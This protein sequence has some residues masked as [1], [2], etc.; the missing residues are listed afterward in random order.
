MPFLNILDHQGWP[1]GVVQAFTWKQFCTAEDWRKKNGIKNENSESLRKIQ[2]KILI[3]Y[4]NF[5]GKNG[6]QIKH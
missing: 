5:Q 3:L 1:G 6:K 2:G 4:H